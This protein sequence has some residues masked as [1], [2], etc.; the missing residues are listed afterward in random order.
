M[1][2]LG[3]CGALVAG[4]VAAG[5]ASGAAAPTRQLA[6]TRADIQS[7]QKM[8]AGEAADASLYLE[9]ARHQLAQGERLMREGEAQKAEMVLRRA[10]A[11]AELAAELAREEQVKRRA[12]ETLDR[13]NRLQTDVSM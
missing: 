6:D 2:R 5:C 10:E 7:A 8:G 9:Y 1:N 3:V 12:Q 13:I 4:A 11:D